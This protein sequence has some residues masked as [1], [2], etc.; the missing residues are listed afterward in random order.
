MQSRSSVVR[1]LVAVGLLAGELVF[2]REASANVPVIDVTNLAQ[3]ILS[4]VNAVK[5]V[6]QQA[7]QLSNDSEMIMQNVQQLQ[8]LVGILQ[9]LQ[10]NSQPGSPLAWGSVDTALQALGESMRIG[11]SIS[12]DLSHL[13]DE[14]EAR[15]PGY[16]APHDWSTAY[17]QWSQTAL[18][19]LR[20]ALVSAGQNVADAPS[21]E[22]SLDAL[23]LA[24]T[25]AAGRL[26]A[27]QVGNELASL[28]ISEMAKLRQ[29]VA[30]QITSQNTYAAS[31]ESRRAG[32]DAALSQFL[33]TGAGPAPVSRPAE[34]LAVVPAP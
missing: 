19:T 13:S 14:F 2:A 30:A 8:Q 34:G 16:V 18:D 11:Q 32:A 24:N 9:D 28:E 5:S 3:N 7:Q 15:F 21:I 23:R 26:Q 31:L 27:I 22:A 20:G 12:Y 1:R 25:S 29:L 10:R 33:G 4:A 17:R 6:A